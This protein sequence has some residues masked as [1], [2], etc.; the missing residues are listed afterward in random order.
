MG[1]FV[2]IYNTLFKGMQIGP[3]THSR[4]V[5]YWPQFRAVQLLRCRT[6]SRYRPV[7]CQTVQCGSD[8][9]QAFVIGFW[10]CVLNNST[11]P[12][13]IYSLKIDLVTVIRSTELLKAETRTAF[14]VAYCL[15][16]LLFCPTLY[17]LVFS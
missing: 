2:A 7:I 10:V 14:M 11:T 6:N 4:N 12:P 9:C 5:N 3:Q 8:F 16:K 17:R 1:P 13:T 15:S